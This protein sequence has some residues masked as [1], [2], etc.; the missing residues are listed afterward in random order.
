[1]EPASGCDSGRFD[2]LGSTKGLSERLLEKRLFPGITPASNASLL[3]TKSEED[4]TMSCDTRI[5]RRSFLAWLGA[6][7]AALVTVGGNRGVAWAQAAPFKKGNRAEIPAAKMQSLAPGV[8]THFPEAR[9]W[10]VSGKDD[11]LAAFDEQCTHKGCK[12]A[13]Q[14]QK[15]YFECPCHGSRFD[16]DGKVVNGPASAPLAHL[17]VEKTKEGSVKLLD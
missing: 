2:F 10:L 14:A 16:R 17:K 6:G 15:S 7:L 8:P 11:K 13:W 1:M 4:F 9:A 5:K 12:F 3:Y